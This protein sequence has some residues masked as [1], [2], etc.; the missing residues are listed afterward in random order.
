MSD[1]EFQL[2]DRCIMCREGSFSRRNW[3]LFACDC[4]LCLNRWLI[5]LEHE[6]GCEMSYFGA[7]EKRWSFSLVGSINSIVKLGRIDGIN[8]DWAALDEIQRIGCHCKLGSWFSRNAIR[9][10]VLDFKA[11][12]QELS[13]A[14]VMRRGGRF[15]QEIQQKLT[16]PMKNTDQSASIHSSS[17]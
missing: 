3:W 10:Y 11:I 9:K 16:E 17:N 13:M 8:S 2:A 15:C 4:W 12:E 5:N 14:F 6:I 1:G 7:T